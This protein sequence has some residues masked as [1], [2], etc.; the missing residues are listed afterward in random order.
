[1]RP[2]SQHLLALFALA[3]LHTLVIILK[4]WTSTHA[5][6]S[7]FTT[8][9][10]LKYTYPGVHNGLLNKG[11]II[12]VAAIRDKACPVKTLQ[13]LIRS[14]SAS[15]DGPLSQMLRDFP[16]QC[17]TAILRGLVFSAA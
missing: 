9:G 14:N 16:R 10:V 17:F 4:Q 15:K 7:S 11:F 6:L 8:L 2:P 3:T 12:P 5:T 13:Y 1:M